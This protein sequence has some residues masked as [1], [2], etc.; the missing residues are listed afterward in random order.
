MATS[1]SDDE[2]LDAWRRSVAMRPACINEPAQW[3]PRVRAAL[4]GDRCSP[5]SASPRALRSASWQLGRAREKQALIDAFERGASDERRRS[6][7]AHA[8]TRCRATST[9]APRALRRRRTRSCSTTCRP[10]TGRARLSRADAVQTPAARALLVNRGWVP[11]G[12]TRRM[13]PD[14]TVAGRAARRLGGRLDAAAAYPGCAS[15]TRTC[16]G[17]TAL[18]ARAAL[19]DA[20]QSSSERSARPVESRIV[21][22]DASRPDGYV[23]D[24]RPAGHVPPERHLGYAVQWFAFAVVALS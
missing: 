16:A 17:D 1:T 10:A 3:Q 19:P 5:R 9:S 15:A 12:A 18:A 24:W 21:L 4:V 13:L 14:V 23:R 7:A 6:A 22:L 2:N 20:A 11:L 8:S